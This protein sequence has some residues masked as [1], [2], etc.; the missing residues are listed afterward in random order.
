MKRDQAA[1]LRRELERQSRRRE[2]RR[3]PAALRR[4]AIAYAREQRD[5]GV[6]ILR[7]AGA[8]GLRVGT[9]RNWLGRRSPVAQAA[10]QRVE[11]VAARAVS[12]PAQP[13]VVTTPRGLRIE[14]LDLDT[15]ARL[16]ARIG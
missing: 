14:G 5:E 2:R 15:L 1:R 4:E 6:S 12:T 7:I 16:I 3:Y 10:F 9:L 8:L 13:L 11:L